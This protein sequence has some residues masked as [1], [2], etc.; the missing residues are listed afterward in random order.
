MPCTVHDTLLMF[1]KF[2]GICL[3]LGHTIIPQLSLSIMNSQRLVA[4]SEKFSDR[5][6]NPH[7]MLAMSMQT[8][9]FI[10]GL[11]QVY[12]K[13]AESWDGDTVGISL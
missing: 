1:N 7:S 8:C 2:Q 4:A 13:E 11:F 12:G 3:T 9:I 6:Q 5:S 10:P